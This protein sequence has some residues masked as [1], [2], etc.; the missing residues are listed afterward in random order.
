MLG[1]TW[2]GIA[3][4]GRMMIAILSKYLIKDHILFRNGFWINNSASLDTRPRLET[5]L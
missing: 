3:A 5:N 1:G 2:A 4:C